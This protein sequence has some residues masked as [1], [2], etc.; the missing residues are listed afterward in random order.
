MQ[1]ALIIL[2]GISVLI[3]YGIYEWAMVKGKARPAPDRYRETAAD[4][5]INPELV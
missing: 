3:S 2:S 1:Q 4:K 5:K